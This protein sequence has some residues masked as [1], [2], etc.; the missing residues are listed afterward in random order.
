MSVDRAHGDL[1][2]VTGKNPEEVRECVGSF[3]S[4]HYHGFMNVC[5]VWT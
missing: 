4:L 1:V 3:R 5:Q 2:T